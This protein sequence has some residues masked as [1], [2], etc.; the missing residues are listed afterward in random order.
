MGKGEGAVTLPGND[1]M[2]FCALLVTVKRLVDK[3]FMHHFDNL[4][5]TSAGFA[6]SPSPGL[7]PW[8]P[9]EQDG[10]DRFFTGSGNTAVSRMRNEKCKFWSTFVAGNEGLTSIG[11]K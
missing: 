2:R 9:L 7:Y 6:P 11:L 1:V 10:D 5:Y 4:S 8:T 3:L